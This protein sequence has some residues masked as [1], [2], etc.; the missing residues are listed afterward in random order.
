MGGLHEKL[1]VIMK[2]L[3]RLE[4]METNI[5]R[6]DRAVTD[7]NRRVDTIER[8]AADFKSSVDFVSCK[9][10]E[11]DTKCGDLDTM[12]RDLYNQKIAIENLNRKLSETEKER[13]ELREKVID[14][15][16]RSMKYNLVFTGLGGESRTEDAEATI[17][18]FIYYE[19]NLNPENI[20]FGNVHRFG[21]FKGR[22][23]RPIVARFLHQKEMKLV[24]DNAY[25][26]KGSN[27]GIN[28]QYP[29]SIEDK[30]RE[31]Y[32]VMKNL[33]R[34]PNNKVRLVRDKLFVNGQLYQGGNESSGQRTTEYVRDR[35]THPQ[36]SGNSSGR[37]RDRGRTDGVRRGAYAG[38]VR[39]RH[40]TYQQAESA[41]NDDRYYECTEG[42][43]NVRDRHDTYPKQVE[44]ARNTE[45]NC[46]GNEGRHSA[47]GSRAQNQ[48][49]HSDDH[50][51]TVFF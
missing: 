50:E 18:D 15:Q 20:K 1:D 43:Q 33:K 22:H 27:M 26:L 35:Y 51:D 11:F 8:T 23:P 14:L 17:R 31:L 10:D 21:K 12:K 36:Q 7:T 41:M 45:R 28:E 37:D 2:K 9:V 47:G 42:G 38:S 49:V 40:D 6:I 39:D 5:Q 46:D 25:R 4:I 29:A 16:C 44:S 30:R 24:K 19:L 3:D 32:P 48:G 34:N 13:N